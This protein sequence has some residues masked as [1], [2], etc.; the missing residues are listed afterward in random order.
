MNSSIPEHE[1]LLA[2][3]GTILLLL[4]VNI[5]FIITW[6]YLRKKKVYALELS[7]LQLEHEQVLLE[8]KVE[9]QEQTL[10]T[11]SHEIHDNIG[12]VLTLAKLNLGRAED[13]Q[14]ILLIKD[15]K[16]LI[17]KAITDLRDISK[18]LHPIEIANDTLDESFRRELKRVEKTGTLNTTFQVQGVVVEMPPDTKI[19]LFRIFQ[20]ALNNALKHSAAHNLLVILAFDQPEISLTINDDGIGFDLSRKKGIGF[21]S[22]AERIK[23][24]GGTLDIESLPGNGTEIRIKV[25][26]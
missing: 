17:A 8:A 26:K 12:Q 20:E 3:A 16:N 11:I 7:K 18:S 1:L 25:K 22:M 23:L 13:S 21:T 24:I 5:V 6:Q 14:D 9:I 19:I 15:T 10:K 4:M 2:I